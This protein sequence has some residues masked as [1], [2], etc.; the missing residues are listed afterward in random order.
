M[1][2]FVHLFSLRKFSEGISSPDSLV[3]IAETAS[4]HLASKHW[5]LCKAGLFLLADLHV[6]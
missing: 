4:E 2:G 5:L 6:I 1:G 3:A